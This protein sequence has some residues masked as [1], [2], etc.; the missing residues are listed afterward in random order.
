MARVVIF[1]DFA[2]EKGYTRPAGPYRVATELRKAGYST[3]VIEHFGDIC[4]ES[5]DHIKPVIDKFVEPDTLMVGFSTT[6]FMWLRS[7]QKQYQAFVKNN[8]Y[9]GVP[10]LGHPFRDEEMYQIFAWIRERAPKAKIVYG[11]TKAGYQVAVGVDIFVLGYSD[12]SAVNLVKYLDRKNPFFQFK[13]KKFRN[14]K[15]YML[16]DDDQKASGFDF[17]N[18]QIVWEVNDLIRY[19]EALPIEI[20]RGC[21]FRCKF[22]SFP[23]NGKSKTD[24]IK[25]PAVLRDEF[26]RNY[27]L[28]GTTHYIYADDTHNDTTQK[29]ETLY[30]EVYSKLPFKINFYS[31]IR[32]DLIAAHKEQADLLADSG[33]RSCIYGVE[34]LHEPSAKSIGKGMHP[35]KIKETLYFLNQR[36]G[37]KITQQ[38]SMIFGLPHDSEDTI[39]NWAS[40]IISKDVPIDGCTFQAL[41]LNPTSLYIW[42][43]EIELNY[44]KFGY[45]FPDGIAPHGPQN[46]YNI[47][48]KLSY[49]RAHELRE[50]FMKRLPLHATK[51][52]SFG[53]PGLLNVGYK[54]DQIM[55]KPY[56]ILTKNVRPGELKKKLVKDYYQRLMAL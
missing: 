45:C 48:T 28:Y 44:E 41:T 20:S 42:K 31:Y 3:Q 38:L 37:Q 13:M 17:V 6:F 11:G 9:Y 50:E 49:E 54:F 55:T 33:L 22:C 29:L 43:S 51:Q 21:I 14:G 35:E 56:S 34:S 47:E 7:S 36:W 26:Q 10:T 27:D 8:A 39:R 30:N 46:W 4:E 52:A 2:G 32:L 25:S 19:G 23:L 16:V 53:V 18:S 24:Y 40:W 12:T 1:S 15:P 5:I